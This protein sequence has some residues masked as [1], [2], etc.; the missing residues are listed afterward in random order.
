MTTPT[1]LFIIAAIPGWGWLLLLLC[2]VVIV[3]FVLVRGGDSAAVS[4]E[5]VPAAQGASPSIETAAG[6]SLA[7]G[8]IAMQSVSN[9]GEFTAPA[10]AAIL[11]PEA[12]DH[13]VEVI[14]PEPDEEARPA[15]T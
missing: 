15:H 13:G 5:P 7:A 12:S 3:G 11:A 2:L 8:A 6:Q 10:P 9:L 4:A 14:P 1:S